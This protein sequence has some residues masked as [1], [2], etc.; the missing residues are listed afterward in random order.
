MEKIWHKLFHRKDGR[1]PAPEKSGKRSKVRLI[2]GLLLVALVITFS[3]IV[4]IGMHQRIDAAV[5]AEKPLL[6][7]GLTNDYIVCISLLIVAL[8]ITFGL[9]PA[10]RHVALCIIGCTIWGLALLVV[11]EAAY[12]CTQTIIHSSDQDDTTKA[13]YAVVI[14]DPLQNK[15]PSPDLEARINT[16]ADWWKERNNKNITIIASNASPATI[17][18]DFDEDAEVVEATVKVEHKGRVKPKGNM[19]STV[20]KNM[21]SDKGV[22]KLKEDKNS[23]NVRQCFEN[24]LNNTLMNKKDTPIVIITNGSYMNDTVRIAKEVG[25]TRISR[26]PA[27]ST[28]NGYLT[29]VLWETWLT[30]DPV[31]KA[32]MEGDT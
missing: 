31:L 21:L 25:F 8:G 14:G 6:R 29:N 23:E 12:M 20:I 32:A 10:K 11:G 13:Y 27:P 26:L 24:V 1:E 22:T 30:Y 2:I 17:E 3:L 5:E 28:F 7:R 18:S 15:Q 19:P 16:A 9:A 4:L